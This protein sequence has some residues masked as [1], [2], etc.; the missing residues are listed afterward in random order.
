MLLSHCFLMFLNIK[1][2]HA[3]FLQH[4][5][6]TNVIFFF[7]TEISWDGLVQTI[8]ILKFDKDQNTNV[9][10]LFFC[11]SAPEEKDAIKGQYE[12][13]MDAYGC[14]GEL[15]LKCGK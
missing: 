15:Q 8:A 3:V 7:L 11:I 9:C 4:F 13:L 10:C 12:K 5:N 6:S 2:T 14:L 1:T